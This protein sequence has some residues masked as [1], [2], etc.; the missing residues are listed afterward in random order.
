[1]WVACKAVSGG[2]GGGKSWMTDA[3]LRLACTPPSHLAV[4]S[5]GSR[6]GAQES[7]LSDGARAPSLH[8]GWRQAGSQC[9]NAQW[10]WRA[11]ALAVDGKWGALRARSP[12]GSVKQEGFPEHL[13]QSQDYHRLL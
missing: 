10:V 11:N 1:M 5:S 13:R 9:V 12:K 3:P 8:S 2:G 6:A 4:N 7:A